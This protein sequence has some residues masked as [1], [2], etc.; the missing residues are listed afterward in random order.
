[1]FKDGR[2]HGLAIKDNL[3]HD[4]SNPIRSLH[5]TLC[6][7]DL[8]NLAMTCVDCTMMTYIDSSTTTHVTIEE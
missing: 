7:M 6:D 1:M 2:F 3:L 8:I 4:F 5:V